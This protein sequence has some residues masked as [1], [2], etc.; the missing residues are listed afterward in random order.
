MC[1]LYILFGK[2]RSMHKI[3]TNTYKSFTNTSYTYNT[4]QNTPVQSQYVLV[5]TNTVKY[6][7]ILINMT[8]HPL[9]VSKYQY[10]QIQSSTNQYSS[11]C[12]ICFNTCKCIPVQT[13][14]YNTYQYIPI[15]VIHANTHCV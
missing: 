11:I 13:I 8:T 7:P 15:H 10:T 5:H 6:Q 14:T 1:Q 12:T 2:S 9:K 4:W 3:L